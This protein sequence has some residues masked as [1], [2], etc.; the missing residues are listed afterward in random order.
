M[1]QDLGVSEAH[2]MEHCD[3]ISEITFNSAPSNHEN[4]ILLWI[5][6]QHYHLVITLLVVV[7]LLLLQHCNCY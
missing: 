3:G 6:T 7:S 4:P 5:P 2:E 1:R